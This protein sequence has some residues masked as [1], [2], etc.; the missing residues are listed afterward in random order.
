[1]K[2]ESPCSDG[3]SDGIYHPIH[4]ILGIPGGSAVKNPP[5]SVAEAGSIPDLERCPRERNGNPL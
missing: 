3:I 1:M 2:H 5:A 4:S